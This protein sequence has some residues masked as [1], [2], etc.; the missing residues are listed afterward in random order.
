[1]ADTDTVVSSLGVK[2]RLLHVCLCVSYKVGRSPY[3][4][5]ST[6]SSVC[7]SECRSWNLVSLWLMERVRAKSLR[8]CCNCL[9]ALVVHVVDSPELISVSQHSSIQTAIVRW[10]MK[11]FPY[12]VTPQKVLMTAWRH[13]TLPSILNGALCPAYITV[14][15]LKWTRTFILIRGSGQEEILCEDQ[16]SIE[17]MLSQ[18][19][20]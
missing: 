16:S 14:L 13:K 1:M 19:W 4:C 12:T 3:L 20:Y 18:M 15:L 7:N 6:W 11:G 9:T 10:K 17:L 5:P 8:C 2:G